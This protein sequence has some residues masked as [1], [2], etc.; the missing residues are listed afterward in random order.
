MRHVV[1]MT[2]LADAVDTYVL[3]EWHVAVG[4]RVEEGDVLATIETDKVQT[5][6]QAPLAGTVVELFAAVDEELSVGDPVCA[7]TS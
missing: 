7:I 2:K 1:K 4:D 5:E 3:L 6:F